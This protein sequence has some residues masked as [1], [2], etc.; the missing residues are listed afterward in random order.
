MPEFLQ[1]NH[2]GRLLNI[3]TD[4]NCYLIGVD[5]GEV[6]AGLPVKFEKNYFDGAVNIE[7]RGRCCVSWCGWIGIWSRAGG[8]GWPWEKFFV[9]R[10]GDDICIFN[11]SKNKIWHP[12]VK[13]GQVWI[14]SKMVKDVPEKERYCFKVIPAPADVLKCPIEWFIFSLPLIRTH[15]GEQVHVHKGVA[16]TLTF[17]HR[18]HGHHLHHQYLVV[19]FMDGHTR[20][21]S[22]PT[23]GQR[24]GKHYI[25]H[26]V[27][28]NYHIK[29]ATDHWGCLM[30]SSGLCRQCI[31]EEQMVDWCSSWQKGKLYH[32]IKCNCQRFSEDFA[33]ILTLWVCGSPMQAK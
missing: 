18:L 24:K 4:R 20:G 31:T 16:D 7:L 25:T 15:E 14:C 5:S 26:E 32:A 2:Q 23:S 12:F 21:F 29:G 17:D 33:K 8:E 10:K 3:I 11:R 30:Q 13:E 19:L 22:W 28:V 6:I 9:D 1:V 27:N